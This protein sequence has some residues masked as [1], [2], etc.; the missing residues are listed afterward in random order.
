MHDLIPLPA[1]GALAIEQAAQERATADAFRTASKAPTTVRAYRADLR[2]FE[3]WC[4]ARAP[5]LPSQS[6]TRLPIIS[7]GVR[8]KAASA[9][10]A[11]AAAPPRSATATSWPASMRT[12]DKHPAGGV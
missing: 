6:R 8:P 7:R 1:A 2:A 11:S 3:D 10:P 12:T 5:E 9:R 4:A